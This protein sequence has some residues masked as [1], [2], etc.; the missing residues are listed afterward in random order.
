MDK[1]IKKLRSSTDPVHVCTSIARFTHA[2]FKN[3]LLT[4]SLYLTTSMCLIESDN[5]SAEKMFNHLIILIKSFCKHIFMSISGPFL[6][7]ASCN[8]SLLM[9]DENIQQFGSTL[10]A[11]LDH[12]FVTIFVTETVKYCK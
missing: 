10:A 8:V 6:A 3:P 12:Q 1:K 2:C 4:L 11:F 5:G 7:F 9:N